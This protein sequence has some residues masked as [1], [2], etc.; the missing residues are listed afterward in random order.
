MV[1]MSITCQSLCN[2][3]PSICIGLLD[4]PTDVTVER[5]SRENMRVSWSPPF[6]LDGV[7]ILDY[8]VYITNQGVSE[9]LT[10]TETNITLRRPCASTIYHI[11]AWNKVER[12]TPLVLMTK[13][14]SMLCTLHYSCHN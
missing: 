1:F 3:D 4:A 6:T 7:P 11:S 8:S 5:I 13:S 12:E 14:A 10:T 2:T 9:Q